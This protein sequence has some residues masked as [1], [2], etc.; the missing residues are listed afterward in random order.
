MKQ[1]EDNPL[2][3]ELYKP[4]VQQIEDHKLVLNLGCGVLLNFE[5]YLARNR[6]V[7][8]HCCDIHSPRVTADEC[9]NINFFIQNVEEPFKLDLSFDIVTFFELIEHID[10]TDILLQN[11]YNAL[12]P[13]GLFIC[14]F[15]NLASIYSR[16]ELLLGYQPHV[17][18]VSNVN[19]NFGTG[20]FGKMNN[21]T[22]A[23]V[24]HI[25]GITMK[26]MKEMLMYFGF[27]IVKVYGYDHRLKHLLRYIPSLAPVNLFIVR[28]NGKPH[29]K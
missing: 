21:S 26:A 27:D 2:S 6:D 22:A 4:A 28:K 23:P 19:A 24:H 18:E 10:K 12:K 17:L 29:V 5:K 15:P 8:I 25:R 16:L 20:L 7:T 3:Q 14:S 1:G 9:E 13:N 11:C